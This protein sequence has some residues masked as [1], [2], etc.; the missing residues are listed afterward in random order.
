MGHYDII[1]YE[2]EMM[3]QHTPY[4]LIGTLGLRPYDW[5][6][7]PFF[8]LYVAVAL[9]S[10][11]IGAVN[12]SLIQAKLAGVDIRQEGSGNPGTTNTLRV[13]GK[14]AAA[15][16]LLV[17][18]L[19][20]SIVVA[21]AGVL[22]GGE[23]AMVACFWVFIGHILPVYYHW[24]GGKGVATAFGGLVAL[25]PVIGLGCLGV[26]LLTVLVTRYVSFGSIGGAIACPVLTI[27]FLPSFITY[28][29]GMGCLVILRHRSNIQ[30]L[31]RHEE[32]KI[33][34]KK[35]E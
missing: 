29:T 28:A 12:P 34:F 35:K 14:K 13:L 11:L 33:S 17:D 10:Y 2:V 31:I 20:G 23:M 9:V 1:G 3:L 5:G 8:G 30:R 25:C 19:K 4:E 16:T 15:I 32:S 18:I 27:F 6:L 22:L 26:V 21:A 24:K 7:L